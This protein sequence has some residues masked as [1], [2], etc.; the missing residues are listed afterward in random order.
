MIFDTLA[1]CRDYQALHPLFSKAFDWLEQ[2]D[3]TQLEPN[4]KILIQGEQLF[5]KTEQYTTFPSAERT[6][7]GHLQYIDIQVII[8]GLEAME[9]AFPTGQEVIDIPYTKEAEIYKVQTQLEGRILLQA[10]YFAIF[11][12]QDLHK[13]CLQ[14]DTAG[15]PVSKVT[16]KVK[17]HSDSVN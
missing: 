17:L 11:F 2:T 7:E 16:L 1:H 4:Q 3:L 15:T 14:Y 8:S 5:A 6:F 9:V 10:N 12:P 13:P